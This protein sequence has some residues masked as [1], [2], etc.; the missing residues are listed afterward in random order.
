MVKYLDTEYNPIGLWQL[1]GNLLDSS[2]N[3]LDLSVSGTERYGD[4]LPGLRGFYAN[5]LIF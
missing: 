4:L 5:F 2:S 3:G 1:D